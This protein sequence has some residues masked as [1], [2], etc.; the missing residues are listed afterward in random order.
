MALDIL[1]AAEVAKLLRV[2]RD[3]VYTLASRG[4]LPG[5]RVG[6]TWR[7]PKDAIESYI[8]ELGAVVAHDGNVAGNHEAN[9]V[10]DETATPDEVRT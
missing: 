5:R 10:M 1:T 3:T 6:R 2:S 8:R 7:F 9:R 4:E